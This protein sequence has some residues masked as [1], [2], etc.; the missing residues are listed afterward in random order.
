[1]PPARVQRHF[2]RR[3]IVA[4]DGRDEIRRRRQPAELDLKVRQ[5]ARDAEREDVARPFAHRRRRQQRQRRRA[6]GI[7]RMGEG[8][9]G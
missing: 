4:D 8:A 2:Q 9:N 3:V 6:L 5:F 7:E 1:M